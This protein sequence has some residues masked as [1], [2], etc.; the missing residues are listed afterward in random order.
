M[1]TCA[2]CKR[3]WD[4]EF[5][6]CPIDG[7]PLH[8]AAAGADINLG[9]SIGTC[10]LVESI[11]NGDLGPIYKAEDPIRGA[12]AI[13]LIAQERI[14]SPILLEALSEAVKLA[15]RL[16]HPNVIRVFGIETAADGSAAVLMEYVTGTDLQSYRRARPG[17]D[18]NEACALVRQ[19]CEGVI[20][21]H[22]M[23]MLHGALHP[24]RIM[25]VQDGTVKVGGFHRS[26]LREGVDVF[27]ATA[28]NLPYLAPEQLGIVRDISGPDYRTD[29]YALGVILYELLAARLPYE[30]G[31]VQELARSIEGSP[32]LP[33]NFS[34]PAVSPLL[35]RVVIKAIVKHPSERQGSVEEFLRELDATRQPTR[36]APRPVS[37][38]P[39][40][41]PPESS[42]FA[43]PPRTTSEPSLFSPPG[44]MESAESIWPE[45]AHERGASGE[46]SFF[47]WFK[48]RTDSTSGAR[49]PQSRAGRGS[50]DDSS[51]TDAR[52]RR[53]DDD[54]SSE[55][56]VIASGDKNR[57]RKRSFSDTFTGFGRRRDE[58]MTGT[59]ALPRRKVPMKVWIIAACAIV[60]VAVLAIGL[61]SVFF[62]TPKGKLI[63]WTT[64]PGAQVL[65][66][67]EPCAEQGFR[68]L[69]SQE[70]PAGIY[71][72]RVQ[73]EGYDAKE[74]RLEVV[75]N[76]DTQRYYELVSKLPPPPSVPVPAPE[77]AAQPAQTPVQPQPAPKLSLATPFYN[78]LRQQSYFPDSPNNAWEILQRWNQSE[79]GTPSPALEEAWQRFCRA[80]EDAGQQKL[81]HKDFAGARQLLDQI[82]SRTAGQPCAA[83]LQAAYEKAVSN[84]K[85]NLL[86]SVQSAMDRQSYVT[87]E[88]ENALKY[89]RHIQNIDPQDSDAK[90]LEG[91]I[92]TRAWDQ[93]AAVAVKRQHQEALDIYQQL[94]SKYP[95]PP[96]GL[97]ALQEAIQ[98]QTQKLEQYQALKTSYSIQVKHGHG[99]SI[100]FWRTRECSGTFRVDGFSLDY[101]ST[102]E[103]DHSFHISYDGLKEAK[104]S[105]NTLTITHPGIR[106]EG[107]IELEEVDNK[108]SPNLSL[109]YKKIMEYRDRYAE[110]I[111]P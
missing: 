37:A 54:E 4:D 73:M 100:A 41:P 3:S 11:A 23:S 102:G 45:A 93:A 31:T 9:K 104:F 47:G 94:R 110:Y 2:T 58:D 98:K 80:V 74:E 32:P 52:P 42:I 44:R 72:V 19:A 65:V 63:V 77:T 90:R 56:T 16:N 30:A 48:T 82:R 81:Y 85:A 84:D 27:T 22:R 26:C 60:A 108:A 20:A 13:Q 33:P 55:R 38:P 99:R 87:P 75:E 97:P 70:L 59:G 92:F 89:I 15:S 51:S 83:G 67:Q 50:W 18:T 109:V 35:S 111:R 88:A 107:R 6:V 105:G 36:E 14:S 68:P 5:R 39:Y 57:K 62:S 12:I 91:E 64:P 76:V 78:A 71:R 43:P 21:S 28:S 106:P 96:V 53:S 103:K 25:V 17:M 61:Y 40:P 69:I 95:N 101:K 46:R 66:C 1:K 86:I 49:R 7:T 29:V 10:R 8:A 34:N 24:A 79:A